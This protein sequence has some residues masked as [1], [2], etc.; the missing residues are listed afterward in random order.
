MDIV[1]RL[2]LSIFFLITSAPALTAQDIQAS[3]SRR[4]SGVPDS[5]L[6]LGVELRQR[7]KKFKDA[8]NANDVAALASLYAEDADYVSPHVPDLMIHGRERITENFENGIAMGGHI[9]SIEVLTLGSSGQL[10]Y[11]VTTYVATNNGVT[12]KGKNVIVMKEVKGEWLIV[13]HA[14]IVRD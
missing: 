5:L 2:S 7:V 14:S 11:M 12:V 1:V 4:G 10:A 9:D 3:A 13:T 8:Y 6:P